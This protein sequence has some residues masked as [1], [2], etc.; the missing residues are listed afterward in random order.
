MNTS[1]GVPTINLKEALAE[2]KNEELIHYSKKSRN[3]L[4]AAWNDDNKTLVRKLIGSYESVLNR[5]SR[6]ITSLD[7]F[8]RMIFELGCLQGMVSCISHVLYCEKKQEEADTAYKG[9]L[10]Y[11]THLSD[12]VKTLAN[13][14][15]LSHTDLSKRLQMKPSTLS[16]AM[17]KIMI[18]DVVASTTSGKYRVY[19]LTDKGIHYA[20][21]LKTVDTKSSL[22]SDAVWEKIDMRRKIKEKYDLLSMNPYEYFSDHVHNNIEKMPLY[23]ATGIYNGMRITIKEEP[24]IIDPAKSK[25]YFGGMFDNGNAKKMMEV[26]L[27]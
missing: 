2:Q 17:K 14:G 3:K 23:S 22:S 25:E 15:S 18:E 12:I 13:E 24:G 6:W 4:L 20:K 27:R 21:Y 5:F 16:E 8:S 10:Q 9:R 11:I 1:M 7:M 19:S 26:T